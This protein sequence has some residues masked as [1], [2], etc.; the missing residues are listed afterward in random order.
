MLKLRSLGDF[1]EN[2]DP[3][4]GNIARVATKHSDISS[5]IVPLALNVSESDDEVLVVLSAVLATL[6]LSLMKQ[7][8]YAV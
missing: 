2:T 3:Q 7:K 5:P 8:V 1:L 4:S 6:N